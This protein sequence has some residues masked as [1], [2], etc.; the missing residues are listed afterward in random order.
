MPK[1]W[2]CNHVFSCLIWKGAAGPMEGKKIAT[3][4]SK[5]G[6]KS[7][8]KHQHKIRILQLPFVFFFYCKSVGIYVLQ[9]M[10]SVF[11]N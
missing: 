8:V 6:K 9:L 11:P 1:F 2:S 7:D 3:P 5:T 4:S 10:H